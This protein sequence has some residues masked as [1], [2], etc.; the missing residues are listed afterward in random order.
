MRRSLPDPCK[1]RWRIEKE[2]EREGFLVTVEIRNGHGRDGDR[3]VNVRK[4]GRWLSGGLFD[5]PRW[6]GHD[7]GEIAMLPG[8]IAR[9][10]EKLAA[11][12]A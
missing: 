6:L 8:L 9:A 2:F 7:H 1:P 3:N 11:S 5:G 4:G 10:R 12:P